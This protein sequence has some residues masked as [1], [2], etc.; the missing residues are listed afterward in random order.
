[1]TLEKWNAMSEAERTAFCA[2]LAEQLVE[3]VRG[4]PLS[5][6]DET[7]PKEPPS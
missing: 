2:V 6:D 4:R 7:D 3:A 1:M 5:P